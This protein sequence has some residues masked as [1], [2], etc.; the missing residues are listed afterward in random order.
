MLSQY[1]RPLLPLLF[2][3]R[4]TFA[5]VV[6]TLIAL[7]SYAQTF[8]GAIN[9]TV[10]DPSGAIV[11]GAT[12]AARDKATGLEH[13][14]VTTSDGQF[15]IQDLPVGAYKVTVTVAGF[16]T[17][18]L[19]NVGI[20]AG[21]IYTLLVKLSMQQQSTTVEVLAATLTLDTT[22]EIQTTLVTG[23]DM[24]QVPLNGRDFTQLIAVTPGFGGY[25]ANGYGSLNGTRANQINW[26]I[27]GVDNNDLWHNLPAVNQAGVAG[28][29]G[30]VLPV[31]S[32][33][34]F[35]A[36][37]QS[38]PDTGR[39]P[40]GT[41][42]LALKSGGN[43]IHGSLYYFN[44][45]EAYST[46]PPF[47]NKKP[48]MRN[49]QYGG[50]VGAP[51]WKDH[52]FAFVSFEK[53]RFTIGVQGLATEPTTAYQALSQQLL[54]YYAVSNNQVTSN[55]LASGGLWPKAALTGAGSPNNFAS[56]DP[57]FG[58][59]YNGLV[60]IDHKLN[61]K[62]SL[63]FHWFAGQGNQVAPVGSNLLYYYEGAPIHVQNYALVWN[64]AI[65]PRLTNQL[66]IGVNYFNQVF[67][68]FNN[69]FKMADYGLYL[70]PS[71][72][73]LGA[74]NIRIAGFDQTGRTPPSGRNDITGHLNEVLSFTTGKHQFRFGGEYRQAQ[75]Q[76]FYHRGALGRF[77]FDGATGPW[78]SDYQA[79]TGYFV[80]ASGCVPGGNGT[81]DYN[82]LSLADFM[83][84]DV[85]SSLLVVG[86][87]VRQVYAN[88]FNL[89]AQDAY[90]VTRKLSLNYGVRYDYIGPFHNSKKDLS[91][92][93]PS[94]GGL[95][96][97]GDG[98]SN[99]FPQDKDNF[100]PRVGF[101]Y[102]VK[103]NGDL[104]VRGS[105]GVFYDAVNLNPFLDNR[106][107]NNGPNGVESN[108]AGPTPV[109]TVEY[110]NYTIP[111]QTYIWPAAG[112]TCQSGNNCVDVGG[113]PV[114]YNIFSVSQ[115]FRAAY[116]YNYN[117]N[118]E[119]GL[120]KAAL[121][122][123]GYVGSEGRKLLTLADINQPLPSVYNTSAA[124]QAARP[125]NSAFNSFGV[126]NQVG[127]EGTSNY[128]SLQATLK[129]KEWHK[130]T[131]Q[132]A[133]T[134]AHSLDEMTLYR[135][136][137]AQDSRKLKG[138]YGNSDFDTRHSFTALV[139]YRLP[140]SEH[141]KLLLNGWQT[142]GLL[143]F[144][145][146]QPFTIYAGSDNS[147]TDEGFQRPNLVGD[148]F[149]GISHQ[150]QTD[151]SGAKFVQWVNPAAFAQPTAGAFGN[152]ARN[153]YYGP[154]YGSVDFSIYKDTKI[155]ERIHTQFRVEIFNLFNRVNMAPPSNYTGGGFG[156]VTDTI[157]D[158]NGAPGIGPG[159]PFNLQLALKIIF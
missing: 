151:S 26:Q 45:N 100:A 58:Y 37:T 63:S 7:T 48:K 55:L 110:D 22:T 149:A 44:R 113:N 119:K 40:G 71:F 133:Y 117:L 39:N 155:I 136:T 42:N 90:Q 20:T 112:P 81:Y 72:D 125:Y 123:I 85:H 101:A 4:V 128:N 65:S 140:G 64:S 62:N 150:I 31:D 147:G 61:D 83:A 131:A 138:D 132:F 5:T 102:R 69:G 141:W 139:N 145:T 142:S 135:G 6:L 78:Y 30:I 116:F 35:S 98:I 51:L 121:L 94:L 32:I 84:G 129:V 97:Q 153:K 87:P 43:Q 82:I 15:A 14:T 67:Y 38:A 25:S 124:Q 36:Q 127:S 46:T 57:E 103:D 88:T 144:H 120:G 11:P 18:A 16:P 114:V 49:Y 19:D 77:N 8:R 118:I 122:D 52:T 41:V 159:E 157:G 95:V 74:S 50:S 28:I 134:W 108:P 143:S 93:V 104:V 158:F 107:G 9:G 1:V 24:Q 13:A 12:V 152:L 27:D 109:E 29:A 146:G 106:P 92:F 70:S 156:Q 3:L 105:V 2:L 68:D 154:G 54:N 34:E 73:L 111:Y 60:K 10:T 89:F 148:P 80:T 47:L 86:D 53:Q 76:E 75:L 66:M 59:S 115:K 99:L 33:D 91:T 23:T 17:Y 56:S 126:I 96:F 137:L 130:T 79:C 21:A